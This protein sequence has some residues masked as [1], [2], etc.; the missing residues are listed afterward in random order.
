MMV[1][2]AR[3]GGSADE[4]AGGYQKYVLQRWY[5]AEIMPTPAMGDDLFLC[6]LGDNC[7][8]YM[9]SPELRKSNGLCEQ[10]RKL[11]EQGEMGRAEEAFRK[12]V[13]VLPY[14]A[15]AAAWLAEILMKRGD[16]ASA[17][18]HFRNA[19]TSCP[20]FGDALFLAGQVRCCVYRVAR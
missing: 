1:H 7:R 17:Y 8:H 19:I 10:G 13:A 9:Y 11:K 5:H 15:Y 14:H 6:D 4:G 2:A 12:A 18:Q 3:E 16:K 20:Y